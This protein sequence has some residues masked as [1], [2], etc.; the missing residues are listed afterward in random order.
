MELLRAIYHQFITIVSCGFVTVCL[1]SVVAVVNNLHISNPLSARRLSSQILLSLT[2]VHI[3]F[4]LL[5]EAHDM[6]AV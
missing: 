1:L 5:T 6:E 3:Y 2:L 4:A